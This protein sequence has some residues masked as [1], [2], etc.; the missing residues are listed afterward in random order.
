MAP[1]RSFHGT[2]IDDVIVSRFAR[3]GA[4]ASSLLLVHGFH[5]AHRAIDS[6]LAVKA[7]GTHA[8]VTTE[9]LGARGLEGH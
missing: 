9:G 8:R 1:Q 2:N 5:F 6:A 3:E 7:L 4:D